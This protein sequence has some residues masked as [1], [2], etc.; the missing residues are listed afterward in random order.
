MKRILIIAA[1]LFSVSTCL[2]VKST[3]AAART[4]KSP[5]WKVG[6]CVQSQTFE[7][8][9]TPEPIV[10]IVEIGKKKYLTRQSRPWTIATGVLLTE[11]VVYLFSSLESEDY[12]KVICPSELTSH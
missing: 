10:Q 9:E 4:R 8:F 7:R 12:K 6:D 1:C 2:T 3:A 5:L 11:D